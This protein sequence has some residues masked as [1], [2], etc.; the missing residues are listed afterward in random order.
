MLAIVAASVTEAVWAIEA[1]AP[2]TARVLAI[3]AI[4]LVTAQALAIAVVTVAESEIG[5]QIEEA[6]AI[7]AGFQIAPVDSAI[8]V[9][10]AA[11]ASAIAACRAVHEVW[12]V[13]SDVT[14]A[15]AG[16]AR[17]P[18]AA[19]AHPVCEVPEEVVVAEVLVVVVVA[20][21]V[22]VA[23]AEGGNER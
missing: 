4:A 5:L 2:A 6:L 11:I 12:A 7:A 22:V 15:A 8:E 19:A 10:Q 20:A 23:V 13:V 1:I 14:T 21:A 16:Q 18:V 9:E 3:E 17:A